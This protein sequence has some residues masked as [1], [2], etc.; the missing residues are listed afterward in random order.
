MTS[1]ASSQPQVEVESAE[2]FAV[3]KAA[4]DRAGATGV[5][6]LTGTWPAG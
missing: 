2:I 3:A 1:Q 6:R 5:R 4:V